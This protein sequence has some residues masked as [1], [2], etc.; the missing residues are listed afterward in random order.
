MFNGRATGAG[1]TLG[2]CAQA[3]TSPSTL[4]QQQADSTAST[5]RGAASGDTPQSAPDLSGLGQ[6]TPYK[7]EVK[8]Q[9]P[10]TPGNYQTTAGQEWVVLTGLGTGGAYGVS[11]VDGFFKSKSYPP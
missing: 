6:Q 11:T 4:I 10:M 7:P 9:S 1:T 3:L 5:G 2:E 8:W